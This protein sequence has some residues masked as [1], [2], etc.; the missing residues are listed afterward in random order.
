MSSIPFLNAPKIYWDDPFP[1]K[2]K[3]N[4]S[5]KTKDHILGMIVGQALGDAYGLST[6]FQTKV[7]IENT[8]KN[9]TIPFFDYIQTPHSSRWKRGDWT[10][11]T[12]QMICIMKSITKYRELNQQDL[13]ASFVNWMKNGIEEC[14]DKCGMG[15]GTMTSKILTHPEFFINPIFVSK[16]INS[17]SSYYP[18]GALMRCSII[19]AYDFE[20]DHTIITNTDK[21]TV[22]THFNNKSRASCIYMNLILKS[23]F[24]SIQYNKNFNP[25]NVV[26][27]AVEKT[28][29][30][31]KFPISE[32]TEFIEAI[33]P[34]NIEIMQFDDEHT[35]G[36][37]YVCLQAFIY[38]LF[39]R[40]P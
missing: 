14:G 6:E 12:D 29:N 19:S 32:Q 2:K 22:L 31:I 24:E 28:L 37:T 15:I 17:L 7:W 8:Y 13:A 5:L 11:D 25:Q 10:D 9:V 33:K 30:N 27:T 34:K 1:N 35:Q 20:Y 16:H 3:N 38:G 18:N 36:H 40:D 26:S 39:S 23:I 4:Y 21:V